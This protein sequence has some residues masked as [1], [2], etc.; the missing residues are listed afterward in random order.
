MALAW[1]Y[2]SGDGP[3]PYELEMLRAV[4]RFG[5]QAVFGRVLGRGE[6]LRMSVAEAIV[7]GRQSM[8]ASS[9]WAEWTK[10]NPGLA[11]LLDD[12]RTAAKGLT[13]GE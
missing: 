6:M 5:G 3:E 7:R 2:A 11:Q 4:D 10:D 12:A 8:M 9:S 1:A 13:D